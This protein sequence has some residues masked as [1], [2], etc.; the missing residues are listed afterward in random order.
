[1]KQILLVF[2]FSLAYSVFNNLSAQPLSSFPKQTTPNFIILDAPT[3]LDLSF[4]TLV[5]RKAD[6]IAFMQPDT[7][8][9]LNIENKYHVQL[10][11]YTEWLAANP[12]ISE[13]VKPKT[14]KDASKITFY[15]QPSG[16]LT[17]KE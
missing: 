17:E 5:F 2:V 10:L 12:T 6:L 11:S 1:M 4:H 9:T 15:V 8:V 16:M 13:R 7:R 14:G 3:D